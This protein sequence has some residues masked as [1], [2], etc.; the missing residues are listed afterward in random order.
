MKTLPDKPSELIRLA[1]HDLEKI[2]GD[3][4]YQFCMA[5]W[6]Y[7]VENGPCFVCLAGAVMG[8]TL[9]AGDREVCFPATFGKRN[10]GRLMALESLARGNFTEAFSRMGIEGTPPLTDFAMPYYREDFEQFKAD[11]LTV[12][13]YFEEG[14]F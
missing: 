2:E 4:R 5:Q 3:E 10:A 12:A 8:G 6:H 1:V 7:P 13:D 9:R 11:L 14:G